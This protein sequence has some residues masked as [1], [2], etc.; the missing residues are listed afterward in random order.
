MRMMTMR[1]LCR[2]YPDWQTTCSL[3]VAYKHTIQQIVIWVRGRHFIL[4]SLDSLA[5]KCRFRCWVKI[6]ILFRSR[7]MDKFAFSGSH[8]E[9]SK[10]AAMWISVQTETLVFWLLMPS[11]FQKCIVFLIPKHIR[12]NW[13]FKHNRPNYFT[14]RLKACAKATG[15]HSEFSQPLENCLLCDNVS[16]PFIL[17][18]VNMR[19]EDVATETKNPTRVCSRWGAARYG[20]VLAVDYMHATTRRHQVLPSRESFRP[21]ESSAMAE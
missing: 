5:E 20:A 13:K 19:N 12:R 4:V 16:A 18:H 11:S 3:H 15:A 7:H 21:G 17:L 1:T 6:S 9:K 10:M 14:K 2:S 8:F